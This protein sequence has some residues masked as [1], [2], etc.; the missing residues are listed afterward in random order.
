[1]G[2][3]KF[4]DRNTLPFCILHCKLNLA[5]HMLPYPYSNA[6]TLNVVQHEK[7]YEILM[8]ACA[9]SLCGGQFTLIEINLFK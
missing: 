1:M 3:C 8:C 6:D 4:K 7:N 5:T 2:K 9:V